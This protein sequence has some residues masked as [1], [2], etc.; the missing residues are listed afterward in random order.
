MCLMRAIVALI[1]GA[2]TLALPVSIRAWDMDVHRLLTRRALDGLPPELKPFY[3][4]KAD[5]VCEHSADPDLWRV[6]ALKG[7]LGEE[8]PNHFVDIDGLDAPPFA[9]VPHEWDAYV[10]KYGLERAN[11]MGRLPWRV[12]EIY[13]KLVAEF[14]NVAKGTGPV[15]AADNV[16]YLSAV[17]AHYL[18]DANQPFHATINFDGQLTDQ[19]GIHARFEGTLVLR[20]WKALTLAP[21]RI[22]PIR[23]ARD[24]AFDALAE[25]QSFV[26][27]VLAADKQAAGGRRV[28]DD[29]YYAVFLKGIEPVLEKRLS[30]SASAVASAIVSAW[31]K[32]GKPVMPLAMKPR[33]TNPRIGAA[34]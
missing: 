31:T 17:I 18:E 23:N 20:S 27:K 14:T 10:K 1:L 12:D 4:Q 34:Q 24:Y 30:D 13:G 26:A 19:L 16:R 6:V 32:A 22:T 2:V 33:N 8:D 3:A 29:A 25:S 11:R 21:V 7:P 5:F 28:Y 9:N 15:W